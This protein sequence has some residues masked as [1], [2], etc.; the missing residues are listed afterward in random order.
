MKIFGVCNASPDSFN[1]DS[2]V[3]GAESAVKRATQLLADGA[4]AI[5]L[6][7]QGSTFMATQV[8]V[9][10]EWA[11]LADLIPAIRAMRS[12]SGRSECRHV[13]YRDHAQVS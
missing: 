7:G 9:E 11:R 12:E 2:I 8:D 4:E 3:I 10:T 13:E 6:G 5:D 1:E